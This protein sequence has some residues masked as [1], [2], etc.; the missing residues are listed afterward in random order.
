LESLNPYTEGVL[1]FSL[2]DKELVVIDGAT[3]LKGATS[4]RWDLP[5]FEKVAK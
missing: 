1:R 2:D 3:S 4:K 5:A